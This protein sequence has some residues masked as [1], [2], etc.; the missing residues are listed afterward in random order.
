MK[1]AQLSATI[2]T[3]LDRS[4]TFGTSSAQ[5]PFSTRA[6]QLLSIAIHYIQAVFST[7]QHRQDGIT[8]VAREFIVIPN[9]PPLSVAAI[10][11]TTSETTVRLVPTV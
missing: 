6:Q 11:Y 8:K 4:A 2:H 1:Q 9:I 7:Q 3:R 10:P 5:P